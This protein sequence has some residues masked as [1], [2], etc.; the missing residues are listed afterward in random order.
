MDEDHSS[1]SSSH[2]EDEEYSGTYS[3]LDDEESELLPSEHND[4]KKTKSLRPPLHVPN[5]MK[6]FEE[7]FDNLKRGKKDALRSLQSLYRTKNVRQSASTDDENNIS[8]PQPQAEVSVPSEILETLV[9]WLPDRDFLMMYMRWAKKSTEHFHSDSISVVQCLHNRYDY[10]NMQELFES[11]QLHY[12]T[13]DLE[14][15]NFGNRISY[16]SQGHEEQD[17]K[18][19]KKKNTGT[20]EENFPIALESLGLSKYISTFG[21]LISGV[22]GLGKIGMREGLGQTFTNRPIFDDRIEEFVLAN[23]MEYHKPNSFEKRIQRCLDHRVLAY[24]LCRHIFHNKKANN[25]VLFS[26]HLTEGARQKHDFLTILSGVCLLFSEYSATAFVKKFWKGSDSQDTFQLAAGRL[27][28][29]ATFRAS[30]QFA[31]ES[32]DPKITVAINRL[33][34]DCEKELYYYGINQNKEYKRNERRFNLLQAFIF[35]S[36]LSSG[37]RNINKLFAVVRNGLNERPAQQVK[38]TG[39]RKKS[40]NTK[41]NLSSKKSKTGSKFFFQR[42]KVDE[43]TA[44]SHVS[45]LLNMEERRKA[46]VSKTSQRKVR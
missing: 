38:K 33:N 31:K 26:M 4:R 5:E 29:E 8:K 39:K 25:I 6:K 36:W 43:R 14:S 15:T 28:K 41:K 10:D 11:R 32:R 3:D 44:K 20:T 1:S 42:D 19:K 23:C 30:S 17:P 16:C 22:A 37:R 24:L 45:F 27:R 7:I 2:E 21:N 34:L 35:Q 9:N 46:H 18:S 40:L 13:A 12:K